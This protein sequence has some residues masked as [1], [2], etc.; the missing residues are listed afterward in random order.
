MTPIFAPPPGLPLCPGAVYAWAVP[1]PEAPPD[2]AGVVTADELA[3]AARYRGDVPRAQFLAMRIAL[4]TTLGR[5]LGLPP[6]EVPI[7]YVGLGK[8]VLADG[9]FQF[10]VTHT[11][12]LGLIAIADRPVGI[13]VE[14]VRAV[15]DSAGLVARFY[16]PAERDQFARLPAAARPAGF[17]RGWTCKEA[18]VKAVG[19]GSAAL[20]AFDVDLNP[21]HP[22]AVLAGRGEPFAGGRWEL[23]AWEPVGAYVA[24]V[25]VRTPA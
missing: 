19:A 10:N 25:A 8:P 23:A 18:V 24:A 6:A 13:D 11:D 12:G 1:L 9:V 20:Q 21:D 2:P 16:S 15:A 22:P 14:R 5:L 17:F 4:R 3:R 7:A